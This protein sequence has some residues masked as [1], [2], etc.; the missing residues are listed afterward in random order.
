MLLDILL[1]PQTN[2]DSLLD[3]VNLLD[4]REGNQVISNTLIRTIDVLSDQIAIFQEDVKNK[5]LSE[6]NKVQ[7]FENYRKLFLDLCNEY[8]TDIINIISVGCGQGSIEPDMDRDLSVFGI[9]THWIG[10]DNFMELKEESFFNNEDNFYLET[11]ENIENYVNFANQN[12]P[13]TF[14]TAN[15]TLVM[16]NLS[17]HHIPLNPQEILDTTRG[18]Q[19]IV[20][21]ELVDREVYKAPLNR[22]ALIGYDLLANCSFNPEWIETA[23]LNPDQYTIQHLSTQEMLETGF[24]IRHTI[25]VPLQAHIAVG[26]KSMY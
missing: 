12:L 21:E 9:M 22:L 7:G 24:D 15:P 16:F 4:L 8:E 2:I 26:P 18:A 11:P 10:I 5:I 19:A 3:R 13:V 6:Y 20:Y 23:V 1:H 14:L 25:D 17:A